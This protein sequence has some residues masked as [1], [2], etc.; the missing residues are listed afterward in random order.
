M[1]KDLTETAILINKGKMDV[2]IPH[3]GKDEIGQLAEAFKGLQ[4]GMR[5]LRKES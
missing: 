5:Y 2:E 1:L 3:M 4:D